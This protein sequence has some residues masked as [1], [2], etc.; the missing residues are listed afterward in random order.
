VTQVCLSTWI[1]VMNFNTN[2]L[3]I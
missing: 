2:E 1:S 3:K